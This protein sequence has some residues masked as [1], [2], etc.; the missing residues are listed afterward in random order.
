MRI[1]TTWGQY[2][3]MIYWGTDHHKGYLSACRVEGKRR[4][5]AMPYAGWVSL[6]DCLRSEAFTKWGKGRPGKLVGDAKG[7][8]SALHRIEQHTVALATHPALNDYAVIGCSEQVLCVW[9]RT[10]NP[11]VWQLTPIR[12]VK[13]VV[14]YPDFEP[15]PIVASGQTT[16]RVTEGLTRWHIRPWRDEYLSYDLFPEDEHLGWSDRH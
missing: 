5:V 16:F 2:Q 15:T 12:G 14:L 13:M 11:T 9:H 10:E 4:S 6:A 1:V 7:T 3:S 8:R